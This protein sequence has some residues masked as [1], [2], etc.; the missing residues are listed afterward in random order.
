MISNTQNALS[1]KIYV[2]FDDVNV[3]MIKKDEDNFA[4]VNGV[5]PLERIVLNIMLS[6]SSTLT[7]KRTQFSIMLAWA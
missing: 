5:V 6:K 4:K 3:G 7:A 1:Q 2:K